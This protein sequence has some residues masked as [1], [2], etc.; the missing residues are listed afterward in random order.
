MAIQVNFR[1]TEKGFHISLL[2]QWA[3]RWDSKEERVKLVP[4][5]IEDREYA[6]GMLRDQDEVFDYLDR[7]ERRVAK[8]PF[9][10]IFSAVPADDRKRQC[11]FERSAIFAIPNGFDGERFDGVGPVDFLVSVGYDMDTDEAKQELS[12]RKAYWQ[13]ESENWVTD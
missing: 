12:R 1:E 2:R 5:N 9:T 4:I 13:R 8:T 6:T 7:K 11:L 3:E 10:V